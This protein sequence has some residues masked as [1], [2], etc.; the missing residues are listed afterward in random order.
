MHPN[1]PRAL[2]ASAGSLLRLPVAVSCSP[3]ALEERLAPLAP[4]WAALATR[5]GRDLF[6]TMLEGCL[7]LALGA[8]GRGL[9][10]EAG[11]R[12]EIELTIP[13]RPPV[14]S[15]NAAVAAA[16]ALFEL[17]RQRSRGRAT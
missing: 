15:L 5:G 7:V 8:E 2:R 12:A 6:A 3:A 1:H 10:E 16:I 13:L 9:S 17:R 4:R 14:E 11:S